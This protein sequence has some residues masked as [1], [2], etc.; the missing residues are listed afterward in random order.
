[1]GRDL[2]N[3][4]TIDGVGI[5]MVDFFTDDIVIQIIGFIGMFLSIISFQ[6]KSYQK[7]IWIRVASEFVFAVQY[8]LLGAYTGMATNL[9]SCVTNSIYRE[10]IKRGKK[11]LGFQ[12]AFGILFAVIGILSWHGPVSLLVIAAKILST[13]ANGNSNPKVLRIFNLIINPLWLIYDIIVFSLAGIFSDAFTII[14]II[15][16]MVRLDKKRKDQIELQ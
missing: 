3:A 5:K 2:I 9:T 7:I 14:S 12:I 10:R 13:V 8:F 6:S 11:T 1:M 4:Q 15:I 16:A